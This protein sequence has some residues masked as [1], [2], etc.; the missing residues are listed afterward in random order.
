MSAAYYP[1][2]QEIYVAYYG[3]PA[4]PAGLQY[5]ASQLAANKGNLTTII[6]AFGNSAESSALYAGASNS[7]KVIAIYQQLFNRAPDTPGLTFYTNA[8]TAGTMTAASIAL[9]VAD[10]ATGVDATYLSNKLV[11]AKAFTDALTTDPAANLAYSGT[12]AEAA[13][14]SLITSV[15]TIAATTSVATTISNIKGDSS[16]GSQA[17]TLT[18]ATKDIINGTTGNDKVAGVFSADDTKNTA[19]TTDTIFD[20]T[21]TDSDT[22]T[23]TTDGDITDLPK[24]TNIEKLVF[25]VDAT[26]SGGD[27][28]FAVDLADASGFTAVNA[29]VA[30]ALS[31][32]NSV[33]ITNLGDGVTV[34]TDSRITTLTLEATD[35]ADM[36]VNASAVGS[37]GAAVTIGITSAGGDIGDNVVTAAGYV[38]LTTSAIGAVTVTAAKNAK[39]TASDAAIL[40]ATAKDGTLEVDAGGAVIAQLTATGDVTVTD[41]G[42]GSLKAVSSAGDVTVAATTSTST[43]VTAA[44]DVTF[45][46][47]NTGEMSVTAG[48]DIDVTA[49]GATTDTQI[50]AGGDV[51]FGGSNT[52]DFKITSGGDV[53]VTG[54]DAKDVTISAD[55]AVSY[56]ATAGTGKISIVAGEDAILVAATHTA[57]VVSAVNDSSLSIN[58]AKTLTVSGNGDEATFDITAM[59]ALA[60]INVEGDNDVTLSVNDDRDGETLVVKDSSS[61]AL[62]VELTTAADLDMRNSDLIDELVVSDDFAGKTLKV[63]SG[64]TVTIDETQ[65]V[66]ANFEAGVASAVAKNEITLVLDDGARDAN[67]VDLVVLQ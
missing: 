19:D 64:Q 31:G 52:G 57:V 17:F 39:V 14:R 26:T 63:T 62:T 32:I 3:R 56:T 45:N 12:A 35:D 48:G 23:F 41:G 55:G 34:S 4:D 66:G 20:A 10:G 27:S 18:T 24:T 9:N 65:G 30:R 46:G 44:G 36:N 38:D 60:R 28:V 58:A 33:N 8:L 6:N 47:A 15:T 49:T 50:T 16:A 53:D 42:K 40:I 61:G 25:N 59:A 29:N 21:S 13:A 11:V 7:A 51:T 54:S 2:V 22:A 43:S 37:K 5:W 67:V 1:Q